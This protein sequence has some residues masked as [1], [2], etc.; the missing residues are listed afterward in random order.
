MILKKSSPLQCSRLEN[1]RDRGAWWAAV[2]GVTQSRTRMKWLISSSSSNTLCCAPCKTSRGTRNV[3]TGNIYSTCT[4]LVTL[5]CNWAQQYH[6]RNNFLVLLHSI[7]SLPLSSAHSDDCP[8]SDW[9][10]W[11]SERDINKQFL[12]WMIQHVTA[13]LE[14]R[15]PSAW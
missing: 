6:T 11:L 9:L 14:Q 2:C 13:M 7:P 15:M 5:H 3:L 10:Q 8:T 1:P 12:P 4:K